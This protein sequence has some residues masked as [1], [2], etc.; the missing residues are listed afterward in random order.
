MAVSNN[1]FFNS[2]VKELY[3]PSLDLSNVSNYVIQKAL[4]YLGA[5]SNIIRLNNSDGTSACIIVMNY[6][7]SQDRETAIA[8]LHQGYNNYFNITKSIIDWGACEEGHEYTGEL[9]INET[10]KNLVFNPGIALHM[11]TVRNTFSPFYDIKKARIEALHEERDGFYKIVVTDTKGIERTEEI[12]YIGSSPLYKRT[13]NGMLHINMLPESE[14][15][16][17][18]VLPSFDSHDYYQYA[19]IDL[20]KWLPT[21]GDGIL[22][23][24]SDNKFS[25]FVKCDDTTLLNKHRIPNCILEWNKLVTAETVNPTTGETSYTI[26]LSKLTSYLQGIRNKHIKCG[27]VFMPSNKGTKVD[28]TEFIEGGEHI[29]C[30]FPTWLQNHNFGESPWRYKFYVTDVYEG[31]QIAMYHLDWRNA[32]VR[33]LYLHCCSLITNAMRTTF[34]EGD[35]K[36]LIQYIDYVK[37]CFL[38]TWGEGTEMQCDVSMY[39]TSE[40]LIEV[41]NGVIN[42]FENSGDLRT[43]P[44]CLLSLA[45]FFNHTFPELYREYIISSN[46]G[47]YYDGVGGHNYN[48]VEETGCGFRYVDSEMNKVYLKHR[49]VPIYLECVQHT[50]KLTPP[51][52][53]H[54]INFARFFRCTYFNIQNVTNFNNECKYNTKAIIRELSRYVGTKLAVLSYFYET[55]GSNVKLTL[56]MMNCGTSKIYHHYWNLYYHLGN[57]NGSISHSYS[58]AFDLTSIPAAFYEDSP[59][60]R[61]AVLVELLIPKADISVNAKTIYLSI[62]DCAGICENMYFCNSSEYMPRNENG[63]YKLLNLDNIND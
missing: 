11:Q 19:N 13:G 28:A 2:I 9:Q 41:S 43:Q 33:R 49:E 18:D 61:D 59:N 16:E 26:D 42:C 38:G 1:A 47:Y 12:G 10:Y 24:K 30:H 40:Q 15:E 36:P 39:P 5:Y 23:D 32:E 4:L 7:I 20:S 21:T 45:S 8:A 50:C 35:T 54:I 29:Y 3:C 31:D 63:L 17:L 52:Y 46:Y 60:W 55:V 34:L 53:R 27:I 62:E 6:R 22:D 37:V 51:S 44:K 25:E 56:R 58:S 57:E 48:F 14:Y